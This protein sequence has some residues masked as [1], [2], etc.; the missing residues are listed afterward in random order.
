M[1]V[2]N[3]DR[4]VGPFRPDLLAYANKLCR[5]PDKAEDVVQEAMIRAWKHWDRF[6]VEEGRDPLPSIRAWLYR[7][8]KNAFINEYARARGE[9]RR[10]ES[11]SRDVT[12]EHV[13]N[14]DEDVRVRQEFQ[15]EG[16]PRLDPRLESALLRLNADFR[17]TLLLEAQ[18]VDYKDIASTL[19]VSIGTVMSRLWR[20]RQQ[21]RALCGAYALLEYGLVS[22][23]K[24]TRKHADRSEAAEV[25]KP[26]A[27]AIHT[28]VVI[29]K[30]A[31]LCVRELGYDPQ[32]S[33]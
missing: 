24:R 29:R 11:A 13:L 25:V 32:T 14:T 26:D 15:F 19:G 16:G 17:K 30:R 3:F 8:V 4:L 31:A 21:M 1:A 5:S 7:V 20:A 12:C 27:D 33:R 22:P 9:R 2:G 28:V 18:G 6:F 10:V 23:G